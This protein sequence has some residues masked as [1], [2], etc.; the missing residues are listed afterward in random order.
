[1]GLLLVLDGG[2]AGYVEVGLGT[3]SP[4]I[5]WVVGDHSVGCGR[6]LVKGGYDVY[7]GVLYAPLFWV[8]V[9]VERLVAFETCVAD[10][11]RLVLGV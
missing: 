11:C 8:D 2:T 1:M 5:V 4:G 3:R 7:G 10:E 6:S 9:V